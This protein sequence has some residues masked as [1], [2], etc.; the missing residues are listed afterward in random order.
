MPDRYLSF[1]C[2]FILS[3]ITTPAVLFSQTSQRDTRNTVEISDTSH[4]PND[5]SAQNQNEKST[6]KLVTKN[7]K[8]DIS[9]CDGRSL[10]GQLQIE[11]PEILTITH[12]VDGL[13]FVKKIK[14]AD[15]KSIEFERWSPN[16]QGKSKDGTIYRFDVSRYRIELPEQTLYVERPIPAY[17][18]RFRFSNRNGDILFYSYWIDLLKTDNSWYTGI[19][20]PATG[21][22][23]FCHKDVLKK[24][25]F[26]KTE[27]SSR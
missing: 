1:I 18:H 8:A 5:T 25:I 6:E 24:I 21:E 13:E 14:I 26:T 15:I 19:Q 10:S 20:G 11:L 22:R 9:L 17:F 3:I 7:L 2:I 4:S 23:P 16:M 27:K 12:S